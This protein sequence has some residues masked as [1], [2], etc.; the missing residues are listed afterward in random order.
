MTPRRGLILETDIFSD[1]DDVGALALA[2]HYADAGLVDLL[3]IGVNT[4]S[5]YGASAARVIN[6]H[7]GRDVP[8]GVLRPQND[9][10]FD[11]D[12]ARLLSEKF[13]APGDRVESPPVLEVHRRALERAADGSVTVVS[14]GFFHNLD[15]LLA[16]PPDAESP[17]S[18]LEL[19][20]RKVSS[21]V[22]MGGW[23]PAGIEFNVAESP[24]VARRVIQ[25]WPTPSLFLG[26]E[27]GVEVITGRT[28][29]LRSGTD[30]VA[31]AYRAFTGAGAGRESWDPL[32]VQLA[33]EG[34]GR[35]FRLSEPGVVE[36][37]D[38]GNTT[39]RTDEGGR[40]RYALARRTPDELA[41]HIDSILQRSPRPGA[42]RGETTAAARPR[43]ERVDERL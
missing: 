29:S 18:G 33:V 2:H 39:F 31:A 38:A 21:L 14:L 11:R 16:S 9:D 23:F 41:A 30:P 22:V 3:A 35:S 27:V 24:R 37:D 12:Y 26:W 36:L 1:V 19:V 13:S 8:V 7:F 43:P 34:P 5:R 28:L 4:P 32:T 25:N 20:R 17:L 40:H 6:R 15:A 10:V 42:G